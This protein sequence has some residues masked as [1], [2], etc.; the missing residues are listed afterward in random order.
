MA[1]YDQQQ[2]KRDS[3]FQ[4][5][6]PFTKADKDWFFGRDDEANDLLSLIL[7]HK[8]TL[9]YAQS[10]AGKTSLLNAKIIPE[11]EE[12]GLHVLPVARVEGYQEKQRTSEAPEY[13]LTGGIMYNPFMY[14]AI[15]YLE[16]SDKSDKPDTSYSNITTL[17]EY[18]DKKIMHQEYVKAAARKK[19]I[20]IIFDQLEELFHV[21]RESSR[22]NQQDFFNQIASVL[23]KENLPL[24]VVLVIREDYLAHLDLFGAILPE[25]LRPRLRLQPL[26]RDEAKE[27]IEKPLEKSKEYFKD[28][29]ISKRVDGLIKGKHE[30]LG[31]KKAETVNGKS[32]SQSPRL[33]DKIVRNLCTMHFD[34]NP[35]KQA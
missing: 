12:N 19:P 5:P 32:E 33:I 28:Y 27:A 15:Q 30:D 20:V 16:A 8:V 18:L 22:E 24:R 3:P 7:G 23:D 31:N 14:N 9:V 17:S 34:F 2:S 1:D 4:G 26:D 6:R 25:K 10:G 29:R 21:S 35:C 11:L 13:S